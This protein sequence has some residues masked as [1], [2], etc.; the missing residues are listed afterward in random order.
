M[1]NIFLL[2]LRKLT[3]RRSSPLSLIRKESSLL[4]KR[5]KSQRAL[6]RFL[7]FSSLNLLLQL[8]AL[9]IK[10]SLPINTLSSFTTLSRLHRKPFNYLMV[11]IL[12]VAL[13]LFKLKCGCQ[14]M[15][16]SKKESVEKKDKLNK[17]SI[18]L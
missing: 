13:A 16:K 14:R 7:T 2:M 11:S 18:H 9:E 1:S 12:L 10:K 3:F 4:R 15:N 8:N 17:F 6:P 5:K